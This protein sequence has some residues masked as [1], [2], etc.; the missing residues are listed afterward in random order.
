[1]RLERQDTCLLLVF[2][3]L[4]A[5]NMLVKEIVLYSFYAPK[6]NAFLNRKTSKSHPLSVRSPPFMMDAHDGRVGLVLSG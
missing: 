3:S 4:P 2:L 5:P 1:M 6:T